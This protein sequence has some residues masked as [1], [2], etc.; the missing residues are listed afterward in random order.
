MNLNDITLNINKIYSLLA[1]KN[2]LPLLPLGGFT[3][4]EDDMVFIEGDGYYG[5]QN[6]KIGWI[7]SVYN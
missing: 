6:G 7:K 1:I 4:I 2:G 3:C 5:L